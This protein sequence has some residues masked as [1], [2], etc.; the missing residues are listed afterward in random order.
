MVSISELYK[1]SENEWSG[2]FKLLKACDEEVFHKSIIEGSWSIEKILR[3]L[4]DSLIQINNNALDT[5][6]ITSD[7]TIKY[8]ENPDDKIPLKIIEEEYHRINKIIKKGIEKITDKNEKE[9][10]IPGKKEIPRGRYLIHL[11][12][13]EHNHFGQVIW[14]FRRLT[15]WS[16][17]KVIEIAYQ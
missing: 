10:I 8:D 7:V 1:L 5:Q 12:A 11:F 3:H 4:I 2:Y 14:I 16:M 17:E 13:H 6:E 9:N 15:K